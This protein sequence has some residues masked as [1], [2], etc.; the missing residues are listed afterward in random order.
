MNPRL[1]SNNPK[2]STR[3]MKTSR[4]VFYIVSYGKNYVYLCSNSNTYVIVTEIVERRI[5][6]IVYVRAT[7]IL[8][9]LTI[10]EIKKRAWVPW[11]WIHFGHYWGGKP[12]SLVHKKILETTVLQGTTR[13]HRYPSIMYPFG[14]TALIATCHVLS[15]RLSTR[16]GWLPCDRARS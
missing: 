11:N 16:S 10:F 6:I 4:N 15:E 14:Y 12:F 9:T 2:G 7:G 3:F 8:L 1:P 5:F 13:Q